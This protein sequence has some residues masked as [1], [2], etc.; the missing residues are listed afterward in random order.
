MVTKIR[1]FEFD[2]PVIEKSRDEAGA[3]RTEFEEIR[4]L[5][6]LVPSASVQTAS[7]G[8]ALPS[9]LLL[10][11]LRDGRLRVVAPIAVKLISEGE[12]VIAEATE[13]NEFGFGKNPSAAL[14]DLQR[15][16]AELYFTLEAEQDRL[17]LELQNVWATL[18]QKIEKRKLECR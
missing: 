18:R 10:G 14:I 13:V 6:G 16:L 7:L 2:Q 4:N 12:H 5:T 9:E 1:P 17:G 15:A 3:Y 11:H 8:P